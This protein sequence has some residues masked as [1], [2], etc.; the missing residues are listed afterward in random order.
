MTLVT[1]FTDSKWNSLSE[2]ILLHVYTSV[3]KNAK[4]KKWSRVADTL[5]QRGINVEAE[6]A[7]LKMRSLKERFSRLKKKDQ[8]IPEAMALAFTE[9]ETSVSESSS[10]A[11]MFLELTFSINVNII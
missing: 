1:F 9:E 2:D 11:G 4:V 8:N 6:V 5:K 7:R 3:Y 10:R